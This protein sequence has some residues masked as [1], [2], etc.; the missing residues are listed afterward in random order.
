MQ[1]YF[2]TKSDAFEF[3]SPPRRSRPITAG[4]TTEL[5]PTESTGRANVWGMQ[6]QLRQLSSAAAAVVCRGMKAMEAGGQTR[7]GGRAEAGVRIALWS[8]F[9]SWIA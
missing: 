2:T 9:Q 1:L 7:E 3:T 8:R 6:S 4:D 5:F